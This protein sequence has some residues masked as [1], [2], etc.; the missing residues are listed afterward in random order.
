ML[1]F[2]TNSYPHVCLLC[3]PDDGRVEEFQLVDF[4]NAHA[5]HNMHVVMAKDVLIDGELVNTV[6]IK[7]ALPDIEDFLDNWI[8]ASILPDSTGMRL[9][10]PTLAK[11][12][13]NVEDIHMASQADTCMA[14]K[15]NHAVAVT[16]I[17]SDDAL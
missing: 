1:F 4:E 7:R 3:A 15:C 13:K 9:T 14:M 10:W 16:S 17:E 8:S 5:N 11:F 12:F 2:F 6:S